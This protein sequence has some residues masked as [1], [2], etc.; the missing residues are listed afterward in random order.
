MTTLTI[1]SEEINDIMKGF[2][3]PEESGLL[4]KRVSETIK[5]ESKEQKVDLSECY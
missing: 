3:F 5:N 2:K 4:R 1:S